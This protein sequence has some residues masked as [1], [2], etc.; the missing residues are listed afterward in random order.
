MLITKLTMDNPSSQGT[1]RYAR[2]FFVTIARVCATLSVCA[3]TITC[4]AAQNQ[5]APTPI[6]VETPAQPSSA[7]LTAGKQLTELG[8]PGV[9]A[10]FSCHG[11]GGKGNGAHFPAIAGQPADYT[12]ARIH[13]FQARA[14]EHTPK[15][16]TMKAVAAALDEQQINEV[17]AY[18]SV[19]KR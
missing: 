12:I 1:H 9:P 10:C 3:Y 6:A 4:V 5:P 2:P 17:A 15:P 13:A 7:V 8:A 14:K 19:T 18:L 16:G 11:A